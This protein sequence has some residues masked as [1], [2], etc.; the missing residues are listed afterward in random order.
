[1]TNYLLDKITL[2]VE[3]LNEIDEYGLALNEQ[4]SKEDMLLSDYRHFLKDNNFNMS[5]AY[6]VALDIKKVGISRANTKK[7]MEIYRVYINNINKLINQDN[8]QL[9]LAEINKKIKP[10]YYP[11]QYRVLTDIEVNDLRRTKLKGKKIRLRG[12]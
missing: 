8:R 5:V 7:D 11:Y 1:M 9:L 2:V 6:K 10:Y 3:L 4:L 12:V